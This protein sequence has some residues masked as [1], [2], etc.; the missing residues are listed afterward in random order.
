[1]GIEPTYLA[2]KA[3]VLPLNYTRKQLLQDCF[4]SHLTNA[5]NRNRT[6]DTRIF[7]PLLYQL[8]YLGIAYSLV[9]CFTTKCILHDFST[10]VKTFFDNILQQ[11]FLPVLHKLHS[12]SALLPFPLDTKLPAN[13]ICQILLSIFS[14]YR[15]Q[16]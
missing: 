9:H 11:F 15:P 5:Q 4:L 10:S 1:M 13:P 3:S 16:T 7:S 14:C 8:S 6:S 2:W 12:P